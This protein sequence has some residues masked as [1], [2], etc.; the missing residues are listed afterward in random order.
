MD[1]KKLHAAMMGVSVG[2]AL[3]VPYEFLVKDTFTCTDMVG[4][5]GSHNQPKG[6]WSDDS[7]M[8]FAA[9]ESLRRLGK[10]D[11]EDMMRNFSLWRRCE[12]FT[13]RGE[14]F[15]IGY[16]TRRAVDRFVSGT[17]AAQCG[18]T[19]ENENGN[20][21]LMRILP[22]VFFPHTDE[23]VR[24]CSS[25]THAHGISVNACRIYLKIAENLLS[26]MDKR[27]AVKVEADFSHP[28]DRIPMIASLPRS[29]ISGKGYAVSSLE[30]SVWC[31]LNT[32]SYRD[33]VLAAVNL[34]DDTDTT[35]AIA[36][37][38]AGILYGI[39]GEKGIPEEWISRLARREWIEELCK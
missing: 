20:G 8:T 5:I 39:G 32:D 23:D 38:L 10:F 7:S 24:V 11:A 3:G 34:G 33:C 36:G 13:A 25:L 12:A 1:S 9:L 37:G 27:D 2:D 29:E 14:V 35:A 4:N 26:G 17:P 15:D 28:F 21:S 16:C 19:G 18:G 30:A 6:T 31:L 22:L